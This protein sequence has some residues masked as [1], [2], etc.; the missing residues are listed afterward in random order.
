MPTS[1]RAA[2]LARVEGMT[3][4]ERIQELLLAGWFYGQGTVTAA[5]PYE[6]KALDLIAALE[7]S[8]AVEALEASG[9]CHCDLAIALSSMATMKL[10]TASQNL[11]WMDSVGPVTVAPGRPKQAVDATQ[12]PR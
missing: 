1:D 4:S 11:G 2:W 8:A 3:R 9:E 10:R 7:R 5:A 6:Q 12:E